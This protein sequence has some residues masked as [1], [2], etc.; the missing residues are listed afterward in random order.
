[1]T[2]DAD[3]TG[4]A[5]GGD[6]KGT[7]RAENLLTTLF[8]QCEL[9]PAGNSIIQNSLWPIGGYF[10]HSIGSHQLPFGVENKLKL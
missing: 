9:S 1:M 2:G 10:I 4:G 6:N 5:G 3:W 7:N 8:L